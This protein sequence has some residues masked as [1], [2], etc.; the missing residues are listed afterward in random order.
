ML[1]F[2]ALYLAVSLTCFACAIRG[3]VP[4]DED[5]VPVSVRS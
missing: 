1:T 4:L 2:A 5:L 3:A